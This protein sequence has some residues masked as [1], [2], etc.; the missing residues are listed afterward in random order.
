MQKSVY[1]HQ[2]NKCKIWSGFFTKYIY[3]CLYKMMAPVSII[4]P[5]FTCQRAIYLKIH[6]LVC[7]LHYNFVII[8]WP[9]FENHWPCTASHCV[10]EALLSKK[11]REREYKSKS[12]SNRDQKRVNVRNSE[13]VSMRIWGCGEHRKKW[14]PKRGEIEESKRKSLWRNKTERGRWKESERWN[15]ET[16]TANVSGCY[17]PDFTY[18]P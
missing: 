12:V 16:T 7:K 3:S 13:R 15:T 6:W 1:L 5:N 18:L 2:L 8:W 9:E 10:L 17:T 11:N 4:F 14:K